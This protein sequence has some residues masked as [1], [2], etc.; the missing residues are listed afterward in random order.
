[1]VRILSLMVEENPSSFS[2]C[3]ETTGTEV[4]QV[5]SSNGEKLPEPPHAHSTETR[6]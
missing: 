5:A 1:M 4:C 3:G 6:N 2:T